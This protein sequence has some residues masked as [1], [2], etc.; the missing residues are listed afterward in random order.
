MYLE[1][2]TDNLELLLN[3]KIS[4]PSQLVEP[5]TGG[6]L[7]FDPGNP[8]NRYDEA[9]KLHNDILRELSEMRNKKKMTRIISMI[10]S[11]C[12]GEAGASKF[13]SVRLKSSR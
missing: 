11:N 1:L 9:G 7:P 13:V 10:G 12:T 5:P 6:S 8:F 2:K 3:S 4:Q